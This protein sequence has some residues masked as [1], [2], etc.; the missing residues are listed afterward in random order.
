MTGMLAR[1]QYLLPKFV[2]KLLVHS[3]FLCMPTILF[4]SISFYPAPRVKDLWSFQWHTNPEMAVNTWDKNKIFD[5]FNSGDK[6]TTNMIETHS[7]RKGYSIR[8]IP[9][10]TPYVSH[11]CLRHRHGNSR[12][13]FAVTKRWI[14]VNHKKKTGTHLSELLKRSD[15]LHYHSL[16]VHFEGIWAS[17]FPR[18]ECHQKQALNTNRDS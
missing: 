10:P 11:H 12:F 2:A 18:Q 17:E 1:E 5:F 3:N 9:V 6:N 15:S 7:L 16:C 4:S 13:L 8:I 14:K